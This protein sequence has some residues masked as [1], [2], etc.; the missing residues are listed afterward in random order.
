MAKDTAEAPVI[1]E[2]E[3]IALCG[4]SDHLAEIVQPEDSRMS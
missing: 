4:A 3:A 2:V 1:V